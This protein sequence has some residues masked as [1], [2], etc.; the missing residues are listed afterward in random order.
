MVKKRGLTR[1][2]FPGRFSELATK[3]KPLSKLNTSLIRHWLASRLAMY[4]LADQTTRLRGEKSEDHSGT[5]RRCGQYA[6]LEAMEVVSHS[7]KYKVYVCQYHQECNQTSYA[8][9][10]KTAKAKSVEFL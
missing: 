1:K 3:P 9:R 2:Y 6:G 10:R 8:S 7:W 4:F 5:G